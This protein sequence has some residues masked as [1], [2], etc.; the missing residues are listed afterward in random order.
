MFKLPDVIPGGV[1]ELLDE[2][3]DGREA[4]GSGLDLRAKDPDPVL[5]GV[6]GEIDED[7]FPHDGGVGGW[8][9]RDAFRKRARRDALLEGFLCVAFGDSAAEFFFVLGVLLAPG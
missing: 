1:G 6:F 2:L 4:F 3:D 9:R 5:V 7:G 8:A